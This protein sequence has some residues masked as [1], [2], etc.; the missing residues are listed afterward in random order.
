MIKGY[1]GSEEKTLNFRSKLGFKQQNIIMNKEQLVT[2]KIIQ[3]FAKE[4]VLLQ[5]SVL[6]YRIDLYFPEHKLAIEVDEKRH[7]DRDMHKEIE[8]QKV[9]EK[10]L[11]CEFS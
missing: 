4:E 7:E 8:R 11:D 6:G 3:L 1:K 10:G 2:T 5:H 9:I